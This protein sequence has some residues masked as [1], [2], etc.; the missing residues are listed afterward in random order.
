[1]ETGLSSVCASVQVSSDLWRPGSVQVMIA[2]ANGGHGAQYPG[3]YRYKRTAADNASQT[4]P[5]AAVNGVMSC[6][7]TA[8][9]R[10]TATGRSARAW[11]YCCIQTES[12]QSSFHPKPHPNRK[13]A[14]LRCCQSGKCLPGGLDQCHFT[15][16]KLLARE[17]TPLRFRL[18]SYG[19]GWRGIELQ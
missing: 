4:L 8:S 5:A 14:T 16:R 9:L 6:A 7:R 2:G 3:G 10:L 15:T 11:R 18:D 17:R 12:E 19:R 13:G 1:M